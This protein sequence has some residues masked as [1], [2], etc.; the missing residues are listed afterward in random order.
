M[1]ANSRGLTM[2][3]IH[4]AE[5]ILGLVTR[6]DRAASIAGDLM[7]E[8]A[9]RGA[10]LFWSGVLRI[11]ASLLWSGI[12]ENPWRIAGVALIGV[13][14]EA[15]ASML[16]AYL[17]GAVFIHAAW[18]GYGIQSNPA[19]FMVALEAS[20]LVI[21]VF[22]GRMLARLSPGQELSACL[23]FAILGSILTLV[24]LFI[25]ARGLGIF[26]MLEVFLSGMA[27]QAPVLVG[28]VWGRHRGQAAN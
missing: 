8:T 7:E 23:A 14:V 13:A 4:I 24:L 28:T 25:S 21:S 1:G 20:V 26:V 9:H 5:W 19:G 6:R 11:M 16:L 3:S 15:V 10:F 12:A 22:V 18:S 2:R 27:R 17:A